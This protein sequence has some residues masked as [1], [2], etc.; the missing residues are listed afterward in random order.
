MGYV[1]PLAFFSSVFL[2][3]ASGLYSLLQ[4][5]SPTGEWVGFQIIGSIGSGA[6]LQVVSLPW[7]NL[8][9]FELTLQPQAIISIQAVVRP[10]EL[11]SA[12]AFL[13]FAQ[14]LGPAIALTLYN[15]I[16]STSLR[17]QLLERA[18]NLDSK[19]IIAAGATGFKAIVPQAELPAVLVAYA[20]SI[21]KTF[22]LVAAMAAA[23]GICCWGMGWNDIRVR[24]SQESDRSIE[25][26]KSEV[27]VD[28]RY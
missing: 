9:D 13:I 14:S 23:C 15:V 2:S 5:G 16:F 21:D 28:A 12:M 18:P 27:K 25:N 4:P 1:I 11:S 24:D 17:S 19:A 7:F 20:N 3:I 6:G 22:Y 26:G 8:Y 10:E